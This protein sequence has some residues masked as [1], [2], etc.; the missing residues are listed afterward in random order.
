VVLLQAIE[1]DGEGEVLAGLEE[2]DFLSS[3][4]ALVQR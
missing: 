3:R 4:R 2:V 1:V